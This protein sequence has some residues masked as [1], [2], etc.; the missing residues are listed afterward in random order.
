M[1]QI[2]SS[3]YFKSCISNQQLSLFLSMEEFIE[4]FLIGIRIL[5]SAL[6]R[7]VHRMSMSII[8]KVI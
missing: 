7:R 2:F 8:T 6:L 5:R 3:L 1:L 4:M